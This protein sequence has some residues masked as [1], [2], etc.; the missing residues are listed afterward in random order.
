[1]RNWRSGVPQGKDS[2]KAD[3][4]GDGRSELAGCRASNE[5]GRLGQ[6]LAEPP[7]MTGLSQMTM[8]GGS[9]PPHV[10]LGTLCAR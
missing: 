2:G 6:V 7:G 5:V 8:G 4:G 10:G 1:M 9:G 3:D